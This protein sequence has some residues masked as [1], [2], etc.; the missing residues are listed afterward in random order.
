ME[1]CSNTSIGV[2][3]HTDGAKAEA[4]QQK[5]TFSRSGLARFE[6]RLKTYKDSYLRF[7]R[8]YTSPFTNNQAEQGLRHV[9][10]K[11]KISGCYRSLAGLIELQQNTLPDV[12]LK[13]GPRHPARY[14]RLLSSP[15][16]SCTVRAG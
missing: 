5:E 9:K 14:P 4:I 8:D 1:P 6:A 3:R 13:N 11:Q 12:H 16:L 2:T 10:I 7:I 15:R